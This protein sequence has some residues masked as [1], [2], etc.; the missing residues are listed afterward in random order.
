MPGVLDSDSPVASFASGLLCVEMQKEREKICGM[1]AEIGEEEC[2]GRRKKVTKNANFS[3]RPTTKSCCT[4]AA[5]DKSF[6]LCFSVCIPPS[7]DFPLPLTCSLARSSFS[8][9]SFG[10]CCMAIESNSPSGSGGH[11][12]LPLGSL[13]YTTSGRIYWPQNTMRTCPC[14]STETGSRPLVVYLFA[15]AIHIR[16]LRHVAARERRRRRRRRR[17][18]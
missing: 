2:A 13:I 8:R 17:K 4:F 7:L 5:E 16:P 9:I 3:P 11:C 12:S 1:T 18:K 14:P 6:R 15:V 10:C